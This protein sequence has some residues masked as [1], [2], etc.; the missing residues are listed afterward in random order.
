MDDGDRDAQLRVYEK[1]RAKDEEKLERM[2]LYGQSP[3]CRWRLLL[4]Y[5]GEEGDGE[6]ES[7]RCGHCDNCVTPLEDQLANA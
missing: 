7:F 6:L 1:R 5:F 2:M 3:L 4:E